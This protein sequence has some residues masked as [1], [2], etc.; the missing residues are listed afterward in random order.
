MAEQ[1]AQELAAKPEPTTRDRLVEAISTHGPITA[2][3]LAER[4]GLTSAA[5]R[6][7]LA[8]LEAEGTN[9]EHEEIGRAHV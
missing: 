1:D 7:H 8:A 3:Q 9:A 4:F 5:V 2:R 6:R